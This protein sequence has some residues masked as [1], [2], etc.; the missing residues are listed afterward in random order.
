MKAVS[1][2]ERSKSPFFGPLPI[3]GVW[4]AV[5]MTRGQFAGIV[6]LSTALFVFIDGPIWSGVHD[7]HFARIVYSYA[8]IPPLVAA[9]LHF[10]GRLGWGLAIAASVVVGLVKLVLTAVI[11]VVVGLANP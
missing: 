1:E 2:V 6:V 7:S 10:N 8:L 11:V 9:A 4:T 3:E 5:G